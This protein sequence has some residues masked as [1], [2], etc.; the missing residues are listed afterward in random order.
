MLHV[1]QSPMAGVPLPD[2]VGSLIVV[3]LDP[4]NSPVTTPVCVPCAT[5]MPLAPSVRVDSDRVWTCEGAVHVPEGEPGVNV[6]WVRSA[7]YT[8]DGDENSA[9]ASA[10]P[11][12]Q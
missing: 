8:L 5:A 7:T 11:V 10:I 1:T 12:E 3:R 2:V 9:G 4:P 6:A